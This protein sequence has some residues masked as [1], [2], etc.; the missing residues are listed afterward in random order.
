MFGMVHKIRCAVLLSTALLALPTFAQAQTGVVMAAPKFV[1]YDNSG[2]PL[3]SGR[4]YTYQC[5]TT[6][7]LTTYS[8]SALSVANANPTVLDSAGRATVYVPAG[9][10]VKYVL[11]TSADATLWTQDN[12]T[13]GPTINPGECQG[14][15]TLTSGTAVTSS[16][17]TG[18]TSVYFTPYRGNR[19]ALYNATLAYWTPSIFTERSVTNAGVTASRPHD[20]FLYDNSGTLTLELTAWTSDTVRATGITLQDGVYVKSGATTRRYLG[21]VYVDASSQFTDSAAKRYVWNYQHRVRRPLQKIES[22]DSWA[23]TATTFRQANNAA[24]NQVDVVVG[25]AEAPLELTVHGASS[26]PSAGVGRAVGIGEDSTTTDSS[27]VKNNLTTA[28]APASV[29]VVNIAELQKYPAIGRHY[30]AWIEKSA[31]TGTTT[32]YG[33][34]GDATYYQAGLVGWI[35]G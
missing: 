19:C 21:T 16:D 35:E 6:T 33:D 17:V 7:A 8:D 28:T 23:Y 13:T 14:R 2:D 25:V 30:Y 18:A 24:T 4:L 1:A 15:L 9:L 12:V 32:W 11:K 3:A 27:T 29:T 10:C 22:T 5:G 31:A 26:N 20:V 34:L